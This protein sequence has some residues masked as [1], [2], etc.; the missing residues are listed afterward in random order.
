MKR[1]GNTLYKFLDILKGNFVTFLSIF[2]KTYG[3]LSEKREII[4]KKFWNYLEKSLIFGEIIKYN[5]RTALRLG[6]RALRHEIPGTRT[7]DS[8]YN[9]VCDYYLQSV[10]YTYDLLLLTIPPGTL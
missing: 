9:D 3:K 10:N 7:W 4:L 5:R 2:G 1:V 6:I 8:F